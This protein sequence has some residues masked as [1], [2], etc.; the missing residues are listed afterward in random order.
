M[1]SGGGGAPSIRRVWPADQPGLPDELTV[2]RAERP[3]AGTWW[4]VS[5]GSPVV[6]ESD[7]ECPAPV[8]AEH[9]VLDSGEARDDRLRLTRGD[10]PRSPVGAD[11]AATLGTRERESIAY[12]ASL[13]PATG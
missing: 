8:L 12:A 10:V 5:D 7:G 11:A 2:L 4:L 3:G 13:L 9:I 1:A 6:V